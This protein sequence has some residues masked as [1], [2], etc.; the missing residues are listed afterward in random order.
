MH[1]HKHAKAHAYH[2]IFTYIDGSHSDVCIGFRGCPSRLDGC[3][4][5]QWYYSPQSKWFWYLM[6][7]PGNKV[8]CRS[9]TYKACILTVFLSFLAVCYYILN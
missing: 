4:A 2:F 7:F 6:N 5:V 3:Y 9:I 1:M 8:G